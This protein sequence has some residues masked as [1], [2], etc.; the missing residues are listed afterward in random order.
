M[1]N[2]V[3]QLPPVPR[4][5]GSGL[6]APFLR[7]P[8]GRS[9]VLPSFDYFQPPFLLRFSRPR[10]PGSSGAAGV[11]LRRGPAPGSGTGRARALPEFVVRG[12]LTE[13]L[14]TGRPR[15][16]GDRRASDTVMMRPAYRI[17]D[18]V[19]AAGTSIAAGKAAPGGARLH[20]QPPQ[21]PCRS[22]RRCSAMGSTWGAGSVA[23][24]AQ[25]AGSISLRAATSATTWRLICSGPG[26]RRPAEGVR[27]AT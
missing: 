12:R 5:S 20:R 3:F 6:L 21:L 2:L 17:E 15:R 4:A 24:Q 14:F 13:V 25:E 9:G 11:E 23:R 8:D 1:T 10:L 27:S 16:Q 18:R 22:R 19:P 7:H 26:Q